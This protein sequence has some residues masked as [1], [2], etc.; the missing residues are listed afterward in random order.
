[1]TMMRF[2]RI[3]FVGLI[4]IVCACVQKPQVSGD[5]DITEQADALFLRAEEKYMAEAYED[6]LVLY[7]DYVERFADQ[8]MAAAAL[9]KVGRIQV[10]LRV[11]R[12]A[13]LPKMR[14]SKS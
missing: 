13:N 1:M 8:P 2:S 7:S 11:T 10:L 6:A 3:F 12:T 5:P 14:G 9:M 4:C